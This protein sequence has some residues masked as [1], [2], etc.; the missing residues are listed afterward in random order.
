M[1]AKK[2]RVRIPSE[3][4]AQVLF[5]SDR[6]CCVCRAKGKPIQIHHID[7]DPSNNNFS[8]LSV[9]CL[10]CHDL[11][12]ITGGFGRKLD[13]DQVRLYRN[14]WI[15][16]VAES[17]KSSAPSISELEDR[18]LELRLA[19][20]IAEINI[21]K[22]DWADLALHYAN[23]GNRELQEK[24]TEKAIATGVSDEMHCYLRS[25]QGRPDLIPAD[26]SEREIR[27]LSEGPYADVTQL[28]RLLRILGRTRDSMR[29][30]AQGMIESLNDDNP[31]SVAY[32]LKEVVQ[33]GIIQDLF[34]EA[35]KEARD[36]GDLWW[37][38]R[39]LEELG[40]RDELAATVQE[41]RVEIEQGGDPFLRRML[42]HADGDMN[43][44]ADTIELIERAEQAVVGP[45]GTSYVVYD[46][47]EPDAK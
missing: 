10:D 18:D 40:W 28:A 15:D 42:Y 35:L 19:T 1:P 37:E 33:E 8:N 43:R 16:S 7:D 26:V 24:Y 30:Y 27:R 36:R 17:R 32:Y 23:I 41:K 38:V 47:D 5:A 22:E 14:H 25:R 46:F 21:E 11:T 45:D 2:K 44:Y 31:F 3:L 20:S 13:A 9:L 34:I 29:N 39:A 6:A 4:A 12:Q